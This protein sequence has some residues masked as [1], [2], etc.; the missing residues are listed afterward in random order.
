MQPKPA[1]QRDDTIAERSC[2]HDEAQVGPTECRHIAGK[3][4]DEQHYPKVNIWI[5]KCVPEKSEVVQV[6]R[7]DIAHPTCEQRI[8]EGSGESD[9][10]Q[11]KVSL[12]SEGMLHLYRF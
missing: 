12:R 2:G 9:R 6:D 7:T 10:E 4:P 3:E 5:E 11:D 8:A 1:Q